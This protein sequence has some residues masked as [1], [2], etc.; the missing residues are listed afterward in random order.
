MQPHPW[1]GGFRSLEKE[2]DEPVAEIDGA[3]PSWLRG[4]LYRNGSGRNELAGQ[5]FAHW[6]DGDGMVSAIRFADGGLRFRNRFVATDNWRSE[7]AA[8]F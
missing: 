5:W 6:F 7:T 3:V 1:S 8:P 2:Y 4:T